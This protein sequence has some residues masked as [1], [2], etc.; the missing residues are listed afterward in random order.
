MASKFKGDFT[1]SDV[2]NIS[3]Q[4]DKAAEIAQVPISLAMKGPIGMRYRATAYSVSKGG[5]P[6][7]L[8]QATSQLNKGRFPQGTLI[9]VAV[10]AV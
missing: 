4:Y 2:E 10:Q 9:K 6:S 1:I 3:D 8:I 5:D 7:I